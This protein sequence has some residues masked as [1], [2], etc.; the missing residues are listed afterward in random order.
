MLETISQ[1]LTTVADE[2]STHLGRSTEEFSA[3]AEAARQTA[4]DAA[5]RLEATGQLL[6]ANG[7]RLAD[8]ARQ[9]EEFRVRA[10]SLIHAAR[11]LAGAAARASGS[12]TE[13]DEAFRQRADRLL[14]MAESLGHRLSAMEQLE[15]QATGAAFSRTANNILESLGSLAIDV[16]RLLEAEIPQKVWQQYKAGD[17]QAFARHLARQGSAEWDA[18]I[19]ERFQ[20][21]GEFRD[22][23]SRY[24]NQ[25]EG[26][27]QQAMKNERTDALAASLLSSDMGKLYVVLAKAI[28]RLH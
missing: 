25:F 1:K 10:D 4:A 8:Y 9:S 11:E 7:L 28:N 26:L 15:R 3:Q 2:A 16:D 12:M 24:L 18:L 5:T 27:L 20:T 23:V 19:A 17:S 22:Y 13:T 6:D 14:D 21:S